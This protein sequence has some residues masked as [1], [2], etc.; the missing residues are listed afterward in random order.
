MPDLPEGITPSGLVDD[1]ALR[2]MQQKL[3]LPTR[4]WT[5]ILRE[6]HDRAF[7]V[8][9]ATKM[10]LLADMKGA[11]ERAIEEGQTL[12]QFRESFDDIVARH[13]WDFRGGRG[14]RSRVIYETNM[15][16]A[17]AAGRYGQMTDPDVLADRPYW[18]YQHSNAL[19]PREH[20]LSWD[21]LVLLATDPWWNAHYPPSGWGCGCYVVTLSEDDLQRLGLEVGEAPDEGTYE[22]TN[23]NT[24]EVEDIPVGIDGGWN[25][26]P[27]ESWVRSQ[28]PAFRE[29]WPSSAVDVG[30]I[31]GPEPAELPPPRSLPETQLLPEGE[32][33]EFYVQ[34]FLDVF[35]T[36]M[37]AEPV[38]VEDAA[39]EI[40]PVSDA[41]FRGRSGALK[42]MKRG[43]ARYA[44]LLARAIRDPDEI[45]VSL[46]P[47]SRSPGSYGV[48]RRYVARY[49]VDGEDEPLFVLFE[50]SSD[51]WY[52]TTAFA[53]DTERYLQ[54]QRQGVRLYRRPADAS[55]P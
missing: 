3:S 5:D 33:P 14:W 53:P 43:R 50:A 29:E 32:E 15:R 36:E 25:H 18:Q 47:F 52:G 38:Y 10:D 9:G 12:D 48:F 1:E 54:G 46:E 17:H 45:W 19:N 30:P 44:Q 20:H 49:E 28:T 51:G 24:G 31:F 6:Q 34:R 22:W 23:P 2:F 13:G 35:G 21:D 42:I 27:G 39:G 7:V 40:L 11:V 26:T 41:L 4:R 37:N 8:A 16:T 55:S